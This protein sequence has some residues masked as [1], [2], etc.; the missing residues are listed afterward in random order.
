MHRG[1]RAR[2]MVGWC[3]F[4]FRARKVRQTPRL[5]I[6]CRSATGQVAV[7]VLVMLDEQL[8]VLE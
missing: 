4:D 3:G 7:L 1:M 2:G 5:H 6:S 8:V